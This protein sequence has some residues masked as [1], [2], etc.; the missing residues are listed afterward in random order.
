MDSSAPR[1]SR[2]PALSLTT[3]A[4]KPAP[5]RGP[6]HAETVGASL[7]AMDS[8]TPRLTSSPALSLTTIAG[9]PAP[10]KDHAHAETVGA[11]LLAMDSSTPRLTSSPAL[12][13]TTIAGKPAPTRE[14][15]CRRQLAGNG[16]QCAA[17]NR[18][19]RVIVN[20]HRWQ[21]SSYKGCAH[22]ETVGASLLAMDSSAPRSSS[23][24][25]LSLTTIAGKPAPT[26][27]VP[28]LKL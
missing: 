20:D 15:V 24:P 25:A 9:K 21:A 19:T 13:L 10:T 1:S 26:R 22:A 4:G 14:R 23:S 28:T 3:I 6:A 8:S 7:L 11:S 12:S 27:G 17:F 18:F 2:L 16:L 5:T